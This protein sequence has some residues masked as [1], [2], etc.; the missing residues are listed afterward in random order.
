MYIP[1]EIINSETYCRFMDYLNLSF[2]IFY[3]F[4]IKKLFI[5]LW[6]HLE[7]CGIL[8][9]QPGIELKSPA[10]EAWSLN[11]WID[12]E[13]PLLLSFTTRYCSFFFFFQNSLALFWCWNQNRRVGK[14]K[15]IHLTSFAIWPNRCFR[16]GSNESSKWHTIW[17]FSF[18]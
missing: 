9:P 18:F 1:F 10:L 4:T 5:Y 14:V 2:F 15:Q 3:F 6:P 16:K 17:S 7:A 11:H 12:R 13:I 8:A